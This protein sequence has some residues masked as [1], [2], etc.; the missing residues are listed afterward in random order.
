[1]EYA[2]DKIVTIAGMGKSGRAAAEYL[3]SVGLDY[4][5]CD[6]DSGFDDCAS[7]LTEYDGYVV[8]S[9]GIPM[10]NLPPVNRYHLINDVELFLRLTRKPTILVTGTNGKT[11]VVSM[12]EHVL[13]HCGVKAIAC[14]NNGLP[15]MQAYQQHA[16]VYILELSS[17]QLENMSSHSCQSAVVL[18]VGIDHVD[19]YVDIDAYEA[20]KKKIYLSSVAEVYP[21]DIQQQVSYR[22]K[23]AGYLSKESALTTEYKVESEFIAKNGSSYCSISELAVRGQHNYLNICA[24][25]ALLDS[26]VL[27]DV[28]I[29]EALKSFR[30]LPHRME[31]VVTDSNGHAWI[32]D[33]KSTNVHS[34]EAALSSCDAPV[35][36]IM[37]GRGKGEEYTGLF[38]RHGAMIKKLI[39][40]GQDGKIIADQAVV[41]NDK[42]VVGT[43]AEA[44]QKAGSCNADVLFSPACASF[45]QYVD[46][47]ERGND[48]KQNV[49]RLVKC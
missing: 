40:Y 12:L 23:I 25:L 16:D 49:M 15:V 19:R 35:C 6:D 18:N 13:V 44:V 46:F 10:T 30:G 38:H 22:G 7:I 5:C 17:Y 4:A 9:P 1:M 20:V 11:T 28:K 33:S 31:Y 21:V 8:K 41:I 42:S 3:T 39:T 24:V 34:L 37:G 36:L 47:N 45:D 48:F 26:F 27:D 32:N 2:R 43:V 14:G 29:I